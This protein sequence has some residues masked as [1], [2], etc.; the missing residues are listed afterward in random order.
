MSLVRFELTKARAVTGSAPAAYTILLQRHL[1]FYI[2]S[3]GEGPSCTSFPPELPAINKNR[4]YGNTPYRR[5]V[6]K[7]TDASPDTVRNPAGSRDMNHFGLYVSE[8]LHA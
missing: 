8:Y 6:I 5:P 1:L 4:L 7:I 2:L 3:S